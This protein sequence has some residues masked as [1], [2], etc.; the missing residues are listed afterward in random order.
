MGKISLKEMNDHKAEKIES[1]D[2]KTSNDMR[3]LELMAKYEQLSDFV[4]TKLHG[5]LECTIPKQPFMEKVYNEVHDDD[6]Q[7]DDDLHIQL[8]IVPGSKLY[9]SELGPETEIAKID[10]PN[11]VEHWGIDYGRIPFTVDMMP[12]AS[13]Y[14]FDMA[15]E[16]KYKLEGLEDGSRDRW[17]KRNADKF[18]SIEDAGDYYDSNWHLL[19]DVDYY[20][21]NL[22]RTSR[23][24]KIQRDQRNVVY[25]NKKEYK[26]V[27]YTKPRAVLTVNGK[28]VDILP[29]QL[30]EKTI[31][32]AKNQDGAVKYKPLTNKQVDSLT[33]LIFGQAQRTIELKKMELIKLTEKVNKEN[34]GVWAYVNFEDKENT[35]TLDLQSNMIENES[36]IGSLDMRS[37]EAAKREVE[38]F[39]KWHEVAVREEESGL[40][41]RDSSKTSKHQ[42][43][44]RDV[45]ER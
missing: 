8:K 44:E 34:K 20:K 23:G 10:P 43:V 24:D 31:G 3:E 27:F 36:T 37:L 15:I 38:D 9:R 12:H 7:K 40:K 18:T 33:N 21:A 14:E 29:E 5:N 17:V 19:T 1:N 25:G 6:Y 32:L 16:F 2:L 26:D 13:E 22:I 42:A 41:F 11:H 35:C 39:V 30:R 45:E 28:E 4:L